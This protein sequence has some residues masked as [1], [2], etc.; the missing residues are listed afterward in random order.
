MCESNILALDAILNKGI[1]WAEKGIIIEKRN[2][3]YT[4]FLPFDL[5]FSKPYP[6]MEHIKMDTKV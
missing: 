2:R 6:A 5:Y 4:K 1:I 3:E